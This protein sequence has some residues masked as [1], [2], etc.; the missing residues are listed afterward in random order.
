MKRRSIQFKL[1]KDLGLAI[2][3]GVIGSLVAIG[4]FFLSGLMITQAAQNVPL[5]GLIV[6]VVC[7]KLFGMVRAVMRYF[8]RILSH[9]TTFT[10]LRDVR[11]QFFNGLIQVVPDI[12]RKFKS[13]DLIARMVSSVEALQNIYLRVYYPPVVIGL[14]ATL[15]MITLFFFSWAHA[16]LLAISMVIAL[17]ILPWLCAKRAQLQQQRAAREEADFL[18]R[19]FDYKEGYEELE[20]FHKQTA[21]RQ[22][23]TNHLERYSRT[24]RKEQRFLTLY[25]FALD[26]V[27]MIALFFC[28]ALGVTQVQNGQLDVIYLT[29]IVL[30]L[31]TLFEQAVSMS[32]VAY[33]K[34]DTDQALLDLDSVM[35]GAPAKK[36]KVDLD[37]TSN[38]SLTVEHMTFKYEHQVN[39]VL[40]GIDL[41]VQPGERIAIVG[42]SGSGKSTLLQ[43]MAGLYQTSSG[44]VQYADQATYD[45]TE[46]QK[47][48][49]FN[50]LLQHQQLFD[51]TVRDNLLSDAGDKE[52]RKVL[53]DLGLDYI[54]LDYVI[55]LSGKGLSG[56]ELQRLC[57]ARLFLKAAPVWLIDEPTRALDWENSQNVMHRLISESE[58]LIVAT[59]DLELL[60]QFDRI[61]VMVE[62]RIIEIGTYPDLMQQQGA[63]YEM[64][65]LN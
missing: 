18:S 9:R 28:V 24:Q 51:G 44:S 32:N 53:N 42:P 33:Y 39:A 40:Q 52:M 43:V 16:V 14:T 64:V 23:V 26:L 47:A 35:K 46:Q 21:Y 65:T 60:Q 41:N 61:A 50:V 22:S 12:Y 20:R 54:D 10:M 38:A 58:T 25:E 31:L 27:S 15:T 49:V 56:G 59:H 13:S 30:M 2:L 8:E 19:Y 29:S 6:L 36:D 37:S 45:L 55:T 3:F 11:A 48:Q 63:L 7:V 62:G 4:M 1:D 34:A 5:Y 57:L 17:G